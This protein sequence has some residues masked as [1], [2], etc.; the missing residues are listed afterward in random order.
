MLLSVGYTL[1]YDWSGVIFS[2]SQVHNFLGILLL[3]TLWC[4]FWLGAPKKCSLFYQH[5]SNENICLGPKQ[6]IFFTIWGLKMGGGSKMRCFA[7]IWGKGFTSTLYLLNVS[8]WMLRPSIWTNPFVILEKKE[9]LCLTKSADYDQ[10]SLH[11][12]YVF[13]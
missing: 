4:I 2:L 8:K 12:S 6:Y 1:P 11:L 7:Y 3:T 9:V 5:F 10:T 13:G